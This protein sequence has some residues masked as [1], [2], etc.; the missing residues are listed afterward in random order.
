MCIMIKLVSPKETVV[1]SCAAGR[2]KHENFVS[3][4]E[5]IKVELPP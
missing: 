1:L 2:V 5:L 3:S 4:N